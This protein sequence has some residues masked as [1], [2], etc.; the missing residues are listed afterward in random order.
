VTLWLL[1]VLAGINLAGGLYLVRYSGDKE[2]QRPEAVQVVGVLLVLTSL[3]LVSVAVK[4]HTQQQIRQQFDH[5]DPSDL[6]V[7]A[8]R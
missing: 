8:P 7:A 4:I 6:H 2:R 1:W 5:H 3:F